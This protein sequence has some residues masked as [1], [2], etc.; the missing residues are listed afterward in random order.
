MVKQT[1][2]GL[3]CCLSAA[4]FAQQVGQ[5]TQEAYYFASSNA[6]NRYFIDKNSIQPRPDIGKNVRAFTSAWVNLTP[7][8]EFPT[9][10]YTQLK[11]LA[12]CATPNRV[13]VVEVVGYSN[14]NT[15]VQT[16]K[17]SVK[18]FQWVQAPDQT[19]F[20]VYWTAVC[21]NVVWP[22]SAAVP[23]TLAHVAQT[24]HKPNPLWDKPKT[25]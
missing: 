8:A 3:L 5:Q 4:A 6:D 7:P 14:K 19:S 25:K 9:L 24:A 15:V 17:V 2:I 1:L 11:M 12:D 13:G 16:E 20:K 10:G 23:G 21:Q 18:D 22:S